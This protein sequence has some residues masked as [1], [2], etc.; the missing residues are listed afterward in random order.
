VRLVVAFG[1]ADVP[2]L[3]ETTVDVPVLVFTFVVAMLAGALPALVP[4]IRAARESSASALKDGFGGYAA[5]AGARSGTLL[6]VGEIALAMM[7]AVAGGLLLKSFARL[8]SV[9]P[10]FDP[11]RVLTLKV[12]LTPPRYRSVASEKP[13]IRAALDRMATISGVE[14]VAAVS[15]LPLGDPASGQPFVIEGRTFAP[16]ERPAAAYRAVSASYFS[17][18]RIALVRGRAFSDGDRE[19]APMVV[20]V[21]D[22]MARKFWPN[23]DPIGQRIRWSTGLAAFDTAPH[24]VVGIAA[25]VKSGGLDK[26][27][28]PAVYAPFPQRTFPWLRWN[29]FVVRTKSDPEAFARTIRQELTA[30]DPQQPVFQIAT[31]DTVVSQ[32]VAARRFNTGLID[33]FA[34]LAIA[35]CAVGVYGTIGYWVAQRAR[36]IGVRMALGATR[37]GIRLM[38][39]SRACALSAAG[40]GLGIVL[41][42]WSGRLLSTL[43]FDVQPFDPTTIAAAALLVLATGA[44]AA[45]I[46]ARRASALDPLTVIRGE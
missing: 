19:D 28:Q 40:V 18:M 36:E 23:E 16:G 6:I 45:Y 33:L 21:N 30:I 31:L 35:L 46:P 39:V 7:L 1:P 20:I 5:A 14:S 41:S 17:T 10:G 3:D 43:L 42:I 11:S 9:E 13:F 26:P 2:R 22:A 4:A 15:Q 44:A 34:A 32:S 8:T 38:I 27:D 25:D 24:T 12:F 37:R 29:S